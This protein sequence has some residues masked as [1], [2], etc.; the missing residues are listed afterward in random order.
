MVDVFDEKDVIVVLAEMPGV[1][2]TDIEVEVKGDV[3]SIAT[4]E[5]APRKYA[6][7]VLL[8]A[9][10]QPDGMKVALKNGVWSCGSIRRRQRRESEPLR[11]GSGTRRRGSEAARKKLS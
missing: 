8:P 3:L 6:A 4:S 1:G 7:E 10:V 2:R 5:S 11:L 9:H